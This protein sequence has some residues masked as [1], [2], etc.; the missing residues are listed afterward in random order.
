MTS[1]PDLSAVDLVSRYRDRSL[2]P[3]EVTE[4][5][6]ARIEA[7]E[8]RLQALWALDAAG[9]RAAAAASAARWAEGRP[10]GPVDGVP[11]TIKDNIATKG[12]PVPVGTAATPLVPAAEE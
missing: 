10:L 12:V 2:S 7:W 6:L 8:P 9:A 11:V 1:L 5:V 3:V 4:A